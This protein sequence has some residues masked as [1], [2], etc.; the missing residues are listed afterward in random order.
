[1]ESEKCSADSSLLFK[2]R[3]DCNLEINRQVVF[4]GAGYFDL[5]GAAH[6]NVTKP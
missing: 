2:I 1:M 4:H 5:I 6:P 3:K